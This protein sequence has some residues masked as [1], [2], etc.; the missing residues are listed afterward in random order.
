MWQ[1]RHTNEMYHSATRKPNKNVLY[2]SDVY[3]GETYNDGLYH[4]KY[5]KR[6]RRN[7][8]WVYYY[9]DAEYSNAKNAYIKAKQEFKNSEKNLIQVNNKSTSVHSS[10]NSTVEDKDNADIALSKAY[11]RYTAAD[12]KYNATEKKWQHVKKKTATRRTIAIGATAVAN[13]FE[14]YKKAGKTLS[15]KIISKIKRKLSNMKK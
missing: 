8:R 12:K 3:L 1:Y 7:G 5:I 14:K 6:E 4:W 13:A 2:H 11:E 10:E 15:K 9:S